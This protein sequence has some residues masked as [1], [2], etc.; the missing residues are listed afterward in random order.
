MKLFKIAFRFCIG[1]TSYT[2]ESI[3]IKGAYNF[4]LAFFLKSNL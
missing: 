1:Y 3:Q 2:E 4:F